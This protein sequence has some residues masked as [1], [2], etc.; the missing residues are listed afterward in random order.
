MPIWFNPK[1]CNYF[2]K[3]WCEKGLLFIKDLFVD[4]KVIYLNYITHTLGLKC[5]FLE[6]E[7]LKRKINILNI[8]VNEY[9]Y[10]YPELPVTLEKIGVGEKR[11][12]R[13]YNILQQK[14]ENI[15]DKVTRNWEAMLNEEICRNE[16]Q[17]GFQII[18]KIPKCVFNK[19][20]QFE[21]LHNRL[22]TPQL[23]CK[24]SIVNSDK[25]LYCKDTVDSAIHALIDCPYT[26][27]LWRDL[28]L[29]LRLNVYN[30]IK[31]SDKEK[32]FGVQ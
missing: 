24:M 20:V 29:W 14:S 27:Q 11:C 4:R 21:I 5:N 13:I 16:V 12:G 26:A 2:N 31:I 28:E 25:C 6:Y 19:Y 32:I 30:S 9:D 1:V 10:I 8:S 15:L 23:L 7:S 3:E 17:K 18:Y 22:N